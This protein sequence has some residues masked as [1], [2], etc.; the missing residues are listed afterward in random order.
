MRIKLDNPALKFHM[1]YLTG[2]KCAVKH[3]V[4]VKKCLHMLSQLQLHADT[5]DHI[6]LV[7]LLHCTML[8]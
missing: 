6:V 1:N 4:N 7:H 3:M 5:H 2:G 8:T